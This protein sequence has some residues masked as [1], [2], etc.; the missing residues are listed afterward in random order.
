MP[1]GRARTTLAVVVPGLVTLVLVSGCGSGHAA[2]DPTAPES[3]ATPVATGTPSGPVTPVAAPVIPK[4]ASA[5]AHRSLAVAAANRAITHFPLPPGSTRIDAPPRHAPR[6]R[7]SHVD[8]VP[9]DPSL[10]RTRWWLVPLPYA[11]LVSWYVAHTPADRNTTS[12]HRGGRSLP[13][14][15][16][17]WRIHSTPKAYSPPVEVVGYAKLG[18]HLTA[19]RTDITLAARA[20]RTKET[21]VPATVTSLQITKRAIDGPDAS[22]RSITVTDPSRISPIVAA[23]DRVRGDYTS[24]G[25][26]CGSPAGLIYRYAVTFHWARHTLVVAAGEPLC[27]IGRSHT[28]DGVKLPETLDEGHQLVRSLKTAFDGS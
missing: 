11:K 26:A 12:Y 19:L 5:G 28:L 9:V 23:F 10:T 16:M 17:Y 21:L 18:P 24:G 4:P 15:Q 3:S 25:T 22:P 6:L 13:Q 20:D 14:A 27:E 8:F 7:R 2:P 1:V